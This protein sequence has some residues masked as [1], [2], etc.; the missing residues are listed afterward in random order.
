[1]SGMLSFHSS[2]QEYKSF[3]HL[4]SSTK[5]LLKKSQLMSLLATKDTRVVLCAADLPV[6]PFEGRIQGNQGADEERLSHKFVSPGP[7]LDTVG[8]VTRRSFLNGCG[9]HA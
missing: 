2:S 6:C 9:E 7:D 3:P 1:M 8:I 4:G 5:L